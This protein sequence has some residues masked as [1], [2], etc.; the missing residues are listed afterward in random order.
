MARPP[1]RLGAD[2]GGFGSGIRDGLSAAYKSLLII[3]SIKIVI[4]L[5]LYFLF[6][7]LVII[8]YTR[9]GPG[10]LDYFWTLFLPGRSAN[11]IGHYPQRLLLLPEI[12]G[13]LDIV[14]DI[15]VY[16]VAQGATIVLIAAALSGRPLDLGNSFA[17]TMK[18]YWRLIG[19]M[20]VATL[21]IL[22]ATYLPRLPSNFGWT[23]HN[24]YIATISSVLLG[25]LVQAFFLYAVPFVIIGGE[26]IFGAI[27]KSI[28]F[29]RR[30]YLLS[31]TLAAVPFIIMLPTFLLG[32]KAQILSLRIYPELITHIQILGEIM[33]VVATYIL[34][35]G[36]TVIFTEEAF[37]GSS[38]EI[39]ETAT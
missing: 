26:S 17:A 4:P 31:L 15:L 30:R 7:L 22:F 24:R 28:R 33:N 18:R 29:A 5:L 39:R 6:E 21:I 32:F 9:V 3:R 37:T 14:L 16:V 25:I 20:F 35:G 2:A 27:A 12:L 38:R 1:V 23:T 36:V 10:S 11:V 8:I 19:V 13:G 34:V